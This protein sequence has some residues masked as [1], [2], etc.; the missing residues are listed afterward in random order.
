MMADDRLRLVAELQNKASAELK[1]L[2]RDMGN[3]KPTPA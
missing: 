3:V 1:N 2:R